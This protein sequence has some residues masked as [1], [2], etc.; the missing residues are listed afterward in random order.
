MI[1]RLNISISAALV[2]HRLAKHNPRQGRRWRPF[3]LSG[4]YVAPVQL[5]GFSGAQIAVIGIAAQVPYSPLRFSV[6][7]WGGIYH[8]PQKK[9]LTSRRFAPSSP[10]TTAG[11]RANTPPKNFAKKFYNIFPWTSC[12]LCITFVSTTKRRV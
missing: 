6:S 2:C 11:F 4:G 10:Q 1:R 9:M 7:G 12:N 5:Y 8:P 3:F